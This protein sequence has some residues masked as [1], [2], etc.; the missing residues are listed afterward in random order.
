MLQANSFV[1][2]GSLQP[3]DFGPPGPF[4]HAIFQARILEWVVMPSARG[5]SR[6][7]DPTEIYYISCIDRRFFTTSATWEVPPACSNNSEKLFFCRHVCMYFCF[8]GVGC[9]CKRSKSFS[10]VFHLIMKC[11]SS[12]Q[13]SSVQ[14]LSHVRL[15]GTL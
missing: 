4:V 5:S 11:I 1:L 12:V 14:S 3:M 6:P 10:F 13:F 8:S 9:E 7:R 15:F 2:S